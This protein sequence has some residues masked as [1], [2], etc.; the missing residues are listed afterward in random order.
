MLE[1]Q[2]G[3]RP[4]TM[5]SLGQRPEKVHRDHQYDHDFVSRGVSALASTCPYSNESTS[6]A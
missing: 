6:L 1:S 2:F 4:I 3:R 5:A